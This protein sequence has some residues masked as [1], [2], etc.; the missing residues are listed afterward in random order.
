M[1]GASRK[2][3]LFSRAKKV[4]QAR[5]LRIPSDPRLRDDLA[6]IQRIVTPRGT[7][8]YHAA[9]TKDGHADRATALALAVHAAAKH[10]E[11]TGLSATAPARVGKNHRRHRPMRTRFA[12][13]WR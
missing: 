1:A 3:E 2:R 8:K 10:P 11:G 7:V 4:F 13:V 9:R 5:N 12:E 6:S